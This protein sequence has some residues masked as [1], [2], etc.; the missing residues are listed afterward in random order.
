MLREL[1]LFTL[2]LTPGHALKFSEF[3][4]LALQVN[5]FVSDIILCVSISQEKSTYN[6]RKESIAADLTS[7]ESHNYVYT[8]PPVDGNET[9]VPLVG[10]G[11]QNC[12]CSAQ[13]ANGMRVV[14]AQESAS[15]EVPLFLMQINAWETAECEC[16]GSRYSN[17]SPELLNNRYM[18]D[19]M[20]GDQKN[21]FCNPNSYYDPLV[22]DIEGQ[23]G[24]MFIFSIVI[25]VVATFTNALT[26]YTRLKV[27]FDVSRQEERA[28]QKK[29]MLNV[30]EQQ[31]VMT[32]NMAMTTVFIGLTEDTP[33]LILSCFFA[34]YKVADGGLDCLKCVQDGNFCKLPIDPTADLIGMISSNPAAFYSV[35]SSIVTILY[36]AGTI[37]YGVIET[38]AEGF[39]FMGVTLMKAESLSRFTCGCFEFDEK[40]QKV[41]VALAFPV[42]YVFALLF[43]VNAVVY[44]KIRDMLHK[45]WT[46]SLVGFIVGIFSMLFFLYWLVP[47]AARYMYNTA[48]NNK[49][50]TIK[51]VATGLDTAGVDNDKLTRAA[52]YLKNIDID[53]LSECEGVTQQ[54]IAAMKG[55]D[56]ETLRAVK[57]SRMDAAAIRAAQGVDISSLQALGES[58]KDLDSEAIHHASE[59]QRMGLDLRKVK[60]N[61]VPLIQQGRGLDPEQIR[62]L[63]DQSFKNMKQISVMPGCVELCARLDLNIHTL[64]KYF[65]YR[66]DRPTF[67]GFD[68]VIT[69]AEIWKRHLRSP[70]GGSISRETLEYIKKIGPHRLLWHERQRR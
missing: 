36:T 14:N 5:D 57:E 63:K 31:S 53:V 22:D 60:D 32:T 44:F 51:E 48:F 4:H 15:W 1:T 67:G 26:V 19:S 39:D 47:A 28:K 12:N 46:P 17:M 20:T 68:E 9:L 38:P 52:K 11:L 2:L 13:P 55:I 65:E 8:A 30:Q 35:I 3:F 27:S 42:V 10:F 59:I 29:F 23:L 18:Y 7:S 62:A 6:E 21:K 24:V 64:R 33:Q 69:S 45:D 70:K 66:N 25:V 54:Q 56:V 34:A 37:A 41:L 49:L 61:I 43:P 40:K 50:T 16:P 58:T